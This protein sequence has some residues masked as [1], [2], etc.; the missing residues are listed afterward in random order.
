MR[1]EQVPVGG[2]G[3]E[4]RAGGHRGGCGVQAVHDD[5]VAQQGGQRHRQR[6]WRGDQ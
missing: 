1:G 5:D 4:L 3:G 6:G 2:D